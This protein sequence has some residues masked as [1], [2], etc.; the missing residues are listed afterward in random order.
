M[1]VSITPL[2]PKRN[3]SGICPD[4]EAHLPHEGCP[5]RK[6]AAPTK[7]PIDPEIAAEIE[8]VWHTFG[9]HAIINHG[10]HNILGILS[11]EEIDQH[12]F[13]LEGYESLDLA[14]QDKFAMFFTVLKRTN[15]IILEYAEQDLLPLTLRQVHYQIVVRH[16]DYHN[17]KAHYDNL[18][19]TL[20][21]ARMAGLVPWNAI[22]DP[23][24]GMHQWKTFAS[25]KANLISAARRHLLDRWRKQKFAPVVL[26]E[27]DAALSILERACDRFYVPY[28][29]L[30]G[31]GSTT[32]LRNAV[33]QHCL[34]AFD[35]DQHPVV[36]HLSDHDCSGWDM[37]RNL[38]WYMNTLVRRKVDVRHIALTLDQIAAGYGDGNPLPPDPAKT[39][40]PRYEKYSLYLEEK[41]FE[42]GAWE[43]DALPPNVINDLIVKEIESLCDKDL[44]KQTEDQEREQGEIITKLAEAYE[45]PDYESIET[46][47][48]AV[49]QLLAESEAA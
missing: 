9:P 5:G 30:K 48:Q 11:P 21:D 10:D 7:F 29:S 42:N 47:L 36:I 39:D 22:D 12:S 38:Q 44:W 24:R 31:Y 4:P 6:R 19:A 8:R 41:G 40:D 43:M 1:A 18:T 35:R 26:V 34:R 37:E 16:K 3:R 27:K 28:E 32:V 14:Q 25:V 49:R 15:A 23:T 46:S 45:E 2:K 13:D 17:N 33:A 20:R